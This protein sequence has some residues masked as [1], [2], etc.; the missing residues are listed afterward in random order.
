ME[1]RV[2]S[3]TEEEEMNQRR[4]LLTLARKG[5]QESID[6]LF[7]FYQVKVFSGDALKKKK[8]PSFPVLKPA[9]TS[10]KGKVKSAKVKEKAQAKAKEKTPTKVKE[11]TP[12]KVK[13]KTPK[14]S[15]SG[16]KAKTKKGKTAK[17]QSAP[18]GTSI[19]HPKAATG[20]PPVQKVKKTTKASLKKTPAAKIHPPK[21]KVS[22]GKSKGKALGSAKKTKITKKK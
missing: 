18:K 3:H 14:V 2:T 12:T 7:E 10:G 13:E 20:K 4:H 16:S 22:G 1:R 21:K 19:V 8:L 6:L 5:D 17:A 9:S 15:L 11:K